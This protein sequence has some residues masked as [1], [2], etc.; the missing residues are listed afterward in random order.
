MVISALPDGPRRPSGDFRGKG[1]YRAMNPAQKGEELGVSG[2][3]PRAQFRR[4]LQMAQATLASV[5]VCALIFWGLDLIAPHLK[6]KRPPAFQWTSA[7]NGA[8]VFYKGQPILRLRGRDGLSATT[9]AQGLAGS[10]D[11]LFN[12]IDPPRLE[13]AVD[14]SGKASVRAGGAVLIEIKSADAEGQSPLVFARGWV[15]RI[16]PLI[17]GKGTEAD[18]CPAC[19]VG[20]LNQVLR[21][22][23]IHA[24]RK[25]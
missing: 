20:R 25:W 16:E 2:L 9:R 8:T 13:V 23:R 14:Q 15:R 17:R 4:S 22:A 11:S 3:E 10:L 18:G 21:E 7:D 24:G 5:A 19:H 12:Q 6:P 1:H